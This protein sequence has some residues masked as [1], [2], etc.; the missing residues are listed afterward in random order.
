[1]R[2]RWAVHQAIP[3]EHLQS[4]QVHH[5]SNTLLL[6]ERRL[7]VQHPYSIT[8][9]LSTHNKEVPTP[10]QCS[11]LHYKQVKCHVPA[12]PLQHLLPSSLTHLAEEIILK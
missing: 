7:S 1:M 10:F 2:K 4:C 9:T 5:C 8:P 12:L 11:P 3:C 6:S